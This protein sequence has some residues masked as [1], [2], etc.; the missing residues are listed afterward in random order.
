[1]SLE[2]RNRYPNI[3][4][5]RTYG[6][7]VVDRPKPFTDPL[8]AMGFTTNQNVGRYRN[9]GDPFSMFDYGAKSTW[10]RNP[11]EGGKS[12]THDYG[13]IAEHFY[14]SK[15]VPTSSINPDG[16]TSLIG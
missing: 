15:P 8:G 13:N 3:K 11:L 2:L 1:M 10:H 9:V 5:T 6:A 16:P 12:L 7:P 4:H 14:S